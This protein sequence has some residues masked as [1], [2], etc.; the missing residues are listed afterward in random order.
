MAKF[1][2]P[3]KRKRGQ[4][5]GECPLHVGKPMTIGWGSTAF[6][7]PLSVVSR[8]ASMYALLSVFMDEGMY[9]LSTAATAPSLWD[10]LLRQASDAFFYTPHIFMAFAS[11][12][13]AAA[14]VATFWIVLGLGRAGEKARQSL[15]ANALRKAKDHRALVL[16]GGFNGLGAT[17]A[18]E[19]VIAAV[20]RHFGDFAFGAPVQV[21]PFPA[22]L[23]VLP[24]RAHP[25]KLRRVAADAAEVMEAC[26]GEVLVWGRKGLFS[27][28]VELRI[29]SYPGFNRPPEMHALEVKLTGGRLGA[30]VEE[31]V[32]YAVA[33]RARPVLNRPQDYKPE[34]LQPIV[35]CL[36]RLIDPPSEGLS[37]A[38]QLELLGDFASGAL[39]LGERGGKA[40]WL[41][42]A[43]EARRRFIDRVDQGA[44]PGAW[45]AA[46]LEVGRALLALG[47]REGARDKLEEA[48]AI[49]KIARDALHAADSLQNYEI[50]KRA[51]ER[52]EQALQQRRR[53]GLKWPV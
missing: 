25:E 11:M 18:R 13:L 16:V 28:A 33:R 47:E 5:R 37:E 32:A 40:A 7:A 38:G 20:E 53:I 3:A 24:A 51:L 17:G 44:D 9:E 31:A 23:P 12:A 45:G 15:R 49:L 27:N 41:E 42:K 46:Q 30:G 4:M 10:Q 22:K 34:K 2:P 39:S 14:I 26:A 36:D 19:E 21:E 29:V 35:E 48:V 8:Q 50:T 6:E 43:L 52:A 1:A